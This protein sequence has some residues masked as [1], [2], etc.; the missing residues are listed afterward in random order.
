MTSYKNCHSREIL[1]K[2]LKSSSP[3]QSGNDGQQLRQANLDDRCSSGGL[4]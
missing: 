3:W 4:K 2:V 1:K